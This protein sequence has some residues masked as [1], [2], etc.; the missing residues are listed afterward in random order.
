MPN[1]CLGDDF[2][3]GFFTMSGVGQS[4]HQK[5]SRHVFGSTCLANFVGHL[6]FGNCDLRLWESKYVIRHMRHLSPEIE[7]MGPK[8]PCFFVA[9]RSLLHFRGFM[10][11]FPMLHFD[12][13]SFSFHVP[14]SVSMLTCCF[15]NWVCK[16]RK[17]VQTQTDWRLLSCSKLAE[18]SENSRFQN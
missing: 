7:G 3:R 17:H 5:G 9:K 13:V 6:C 14:F 12:G 10:F 15:H 2:F 11:S 18:S 16:T 8:N 4:R 1:E